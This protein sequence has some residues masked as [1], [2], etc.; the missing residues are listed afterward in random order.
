MRLVSVIF[1]LVFYFQC[2]SLN[3]QVNLQVGYEIFTSSYYPTK[4]PVV[5]Y[6]NSDITIFQEKPSQWVLWEKEAGITEAPPF[7]STGKAEI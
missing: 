2:L 4:Y 6:I 1:S 7:A 3:G 5:L